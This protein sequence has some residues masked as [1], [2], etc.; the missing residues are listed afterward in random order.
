MDLTCRLHLVGEQA[1]VAVDG[2]IDVATVPL[3]RDELLRAVH[4]CR[5]RL[6]VVDL[7]G[8]LS[9]AASRQHYL[10]APRRDWDAFFEACG[11][12]PVIDAGLEV[13]GVQTT[14]SR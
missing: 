6:V 7:D 11:D 2:A 13:L 4:R 14:G 3:L 12:D 9:D 5:G 8:V 1:V 10:E